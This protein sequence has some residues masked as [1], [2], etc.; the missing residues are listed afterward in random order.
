ML[1]LCLSACATQYS[2]LATSSNGDSQISEIV[3]GEEATVITSILEGIREV[4]PA[5]SIQKISDFSYSWFHQPLLDRTNYRLAI[6]S[7]K[8][9]SSNGTAQTG[10]FFAVNTSGTQGLVEARYLNPLKAAIYKIYEKNGLKLVQVTSVV[11]VPI[12]SGGVFVAEVKACYEALSKDSALLPLGSKVALASTSEQ[13]FSMLTNASKPTKVEQALILVWGTKQEECIR[14]QKKANE[15][16]RVAPQVRTL[17]ETYATTQQS[18]IAQLY[19][20]KLTYADFAAKRQGIAN[21]TNEAIVNVQGVLAKQEADAQAKADQI[22]LQA[23]QN[24]IL[25]LQG[26][27]QAVQQQHQNSLL[28]QQNNILQQQQQTIISPPRRT[29]TTC[30]FY[31]NTM[32]L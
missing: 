18:L 2:S 24:M 16:Q 19:L 31:G 9:V 28:Q 32:F 11:E 13:N 20:G 4:F 29:G 22:A 7:A 10:F 6:K 17:L 25:A 27:T 21:T 26:V 5:A 14:L 1:A 3:I 8:G 23:D 12:N 30:S 15:A